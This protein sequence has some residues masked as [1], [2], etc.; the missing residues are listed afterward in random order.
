[1]AKTL[2]LNKKSWDITLDS[3]GRM[4][5]AHGPYAVAQNVANA[6]RL[7]TRDAYFNQAD[8]VPH[9]TVDL[10]Q[11]PSPSVVRSRINKAARATP[12]VAS[13]STALTKFE[14]RTLEGDITIITTSG[15]TVNVTL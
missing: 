10:G 1:M 12:E 2:L 14:G 5:T 11:R 6:V 15:E 7:F 8:G 4:A 13:A 9:F 3:A